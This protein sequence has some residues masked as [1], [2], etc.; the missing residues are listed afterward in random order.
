MAKLFEILKQ[1]FDIILVDT[2]PL[3]TG[4]GTATLSR[5]VDGV[6][7]VIKA[8]GLSSASLNEAINCIPNKKIVGAVINQ[9]RSNQS[10]YYR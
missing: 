10:Y 6:I 4:S 8:G 3:D 1:R 9:V 5:L 2:M 7:L